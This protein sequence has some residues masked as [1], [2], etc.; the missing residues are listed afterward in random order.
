MGAWLSASHLIYLLIDQNRHICFLQGDLGESFITQLDILLVILI[1]WLPFTWTWGWLSDWNCWYSLKTGLIA[2][3]RES[4][5]RR[6]EQTSCPPLLLTNTVYCWFGSPSKM[7]FLIMQWL[8]LPCNHG[9]DFW[10]SR[11]LEEKTWFGCNS[12]FSKVLR[13][14]CCQLL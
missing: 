1:S 2:S 10:K 4:K 9:P 12:C 3:H 13:E 7:F 5:R 8:C 14:I 11:S 6:C